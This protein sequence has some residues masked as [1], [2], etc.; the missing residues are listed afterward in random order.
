MWILFF[1]TVNITGHPQDQS[2]TTGENINFHVE[3]T[4]YDVLQFQWQKNDKDIDFNDSRFRS[5]K[6]NGGSTLHIWCVEK[7]DA[8]CYRCLVKNA[9]EE[10]GK[11]SFEAKLRVCK[12]VVFLFH[13]ISW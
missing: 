2:A 1:L 7:S 4:G 8:G 12:S 13:F 10:S 3:A 11:P 5:K 9:F 6:T